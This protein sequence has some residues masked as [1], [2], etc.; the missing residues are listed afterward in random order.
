MR[1]AERAGF[2][3]EGLLRSWMELGGQRRDMLLYA[4]VAADGPP[5]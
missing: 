3:R 1:T 2:Q 5:A 4:R